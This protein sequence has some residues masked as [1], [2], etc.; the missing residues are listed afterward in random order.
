MRPVSQSAPFV[1][2]PPQDDEEPWMASRGSPRHS[3]PDPTDVM[4]APVHSPSGRGLGAA[5]G[6][7]LHPRSRHY[8]Q[9]PP[10]YI[11][12]IF[13]IFL[14]FRACPPSR[15]FN[16]G[17]LIDCG[18]IG[19][20]SFKA[21]AGFREPLSSPGWYPSVYVSQIQIL[22]FPTRDIG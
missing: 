17:T 21:K 15:E 16:D 19:R 13:W 8:F 20:F 10:R 4:M 22:I 5:A 1:V 18:R 3:A 12:L 7:P 2:P 6:W 9:P 14:S 11:L